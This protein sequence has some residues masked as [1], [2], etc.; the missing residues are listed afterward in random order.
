MSGC[1][2]RQ[3][4]QSPD[5]P[6]TSV[7]WSLQNSAG[8]G[9]TRTACHFGVVADKQCTCPASRPMRERYPPTPPISTQ[10]GENEIQVSLISSTFSG[11]DTPHPCY[12][13]FT[14][15]CPGCPAVTRVSPNKPEATTG[16]LPALPTIWTRSSNQGSNPLSA[17]RLWV[18]I[19]SGPPLPGGGQRSRRLNPALLQNKSPVPSWFHRGISARGVGATS[20]LG[21]EVDRQVQVLPH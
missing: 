4:H 11:C 10:A 15:K 5:K 3:P 19:P 13:P 21:T 6:G 9:S 7:R 16:A 20:W 1:D 14:G 17:G 18:Q 8:R 12:H 2:S